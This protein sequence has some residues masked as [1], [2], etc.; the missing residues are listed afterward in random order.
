[1]HDR[2]PRPRDAALLVLAALVALATPAH[3]APSAWVPG[4]FH[5]TV[6]GIKVSKV[7]GLTA[8]VLGAVALQKL[9]VFV[10]GTWLRRAVVG[11]K[12]ADAVLER[13]DRPIGG[14]AMAAVFRVGLP[15]FDLPPRVGEVALLATNVLAATSVVWLGYRLIDVLADWLASKA[16]KTHT[17]LDDQLVPL[18]RK[19]FKIFTA[20][21]GGI[22]VLQ[23]LHVDVGSLLA[24]LG[25]GGLA[26]ALAAK[27]AVA[28]V[29]GSIMIFI[30]K[31]FQIGDWIKIAGVEGTV[32]QVGFRTLRLRTFYDSIVILPTGMVTT[33]VI[34]NL[35]L[36]RWRRYEATL[37][38][39]YGTPPE[40]VQAFL[41]GARAII[42]ALP[43]MRKDY[44]LVELR[45]LG[46]SGL[47]AELYCFVD[48]PDWATECRTRTHLNLEI[49]R[50]ADALGVR[51]AFPTQSLHV[52]ALP[53]RDRLAAASTGPAADPTAL[54]EVVRAFGP[55]G[56][57]ARPGGVTITEGYEPVEKIERGDG[58]EGDG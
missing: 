36:R 41:E 21:I 43:G 3:A 20:V 54:A 14:L 56:R 38:L 57:L 40:K 22:F 25:L 7:L 13:G 19:T 49:L 29:F 10:L 52:E 15:S 16:E 8:L 9:V 28:N 51:F 55:G 5:E 35:G 50:L 32:E 27:D 48:A 2:R 4:W 6:L 18:L 26:F 42:Q 39:R 37:Q 30:D 58:G 24:G 46:V 1:M 53:D 11:I 44:Y 17:K 23:N 33:A 31:P 45:T 47:E 34:D 12:W